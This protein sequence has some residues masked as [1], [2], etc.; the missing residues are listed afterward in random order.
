MEHKLVSVILAQRVRLSSHLLYSASIYIRKYQSSESYL[1]MKNAYC[2]IIS[3]YCHVTKLRTCLLFFLK[4]NGNRM[5]YEVL[6]LKMGKV[7]MLIMKKK[8][9]LVF[10]IV[11][12]RGITELRGD[13]I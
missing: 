7:I 8:N 13:V 5:T 2:Q 9:F 3:F 10:A 4:R 12:S 11:K 6:F 1:R